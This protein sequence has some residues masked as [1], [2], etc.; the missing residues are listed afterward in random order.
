MWFY[1]VFSWYVVNNICFWY[2]IQLLFVFNEGT[3]ALDEVSDLDADIPQEGVARPSSHDHYS[4]WIQFVK[5]DFHENPDQRKWGPTSLC[6]NS[7]IYLPK[8]IVTNPRNL[9]VI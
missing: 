6:K 9:F 4:L 2:C 7:S 1:I 8:E 5:K 3:D